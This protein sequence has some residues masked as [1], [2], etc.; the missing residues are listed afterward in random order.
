MSLLTDSLV[1]TSSRSLQVRR[2]PDLVVRRQNYLS[3]SYWVVKDPIGLKYFR[4]RDGEYAIL[5]MLDAECTLDEIKRRY[6]EQ[7]APQRI[8]IEELDR[9]I[10]QLHQHNLVVTSAPGQGEQLKQRRNKKSQQE[11]LSKFT[12]VLAIRFRG[13]DPDRLLTRI[14]PWVRWLFTGPAALAYCVLA[15]SALLLVLVQFEVF[16]GKL[17]GFQQFFAPTNWLLLAAVLGV[18]KVLH[19]FGHGLMCKHFK[20]ECHEMG[21]MLLVLTPCLYC[22]VSDSWLLPSK[23]QRAAIGAAGIFVELILASICTFVWWFTQPG[24]INSICLSVMFVSSVSTILFNG[25]PLLRYDGYYILSDLMEIPNLRQKSSAILTRQLGKWC[26]G[27][28]P[29]EDPFLPRTNLAMFAAYAM[30]SFVYRWIVVLGIMFFLYKIFEPYGLEIFGQIM[31]AVSL[32]GLVVQPL[33]KLFKYFRVPGRMEK[34]K[35]R[36]LLLSLGIG[37][38]LLAAILLIPIPHR[39]YCPVEVEPYGAAPVYIEVPGRLIEVLVEPGA[40]VTKGQLLARLEDLDL[41]LQVA[42]LAGRR[43]E[44]SAQLAALTRARF[45]DPLAD[46]E[47]AGVRETLEAV[48]EELQSKQRQQ[49]KLQLVAEKDG[50]VLPGLY[51]DPPPVEQG[52]LRPWSGALMDTRNEGAWCEKGILFCR[53]GDPR[54]LQALLVVDEE[55]IEFVAKQ[56]TLEILLDSSPGDPLMSQLEKV[57]RARMKTASSRLS[58]SAGGELVTESDERGRH[59]LAQTAYQAVAILPK[60]ASPV[61]LGVRGQAKIFVGSQSIG[62]RIWRYVMRTFAFHL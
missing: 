43:A 50:V 13:I 36:N 1:S 53:V 11:L 22:D 31:V 47:L 60:E 34:V 21:V 3:Q 41:D 18:T 29:P 20:G 35:P 48:T 45:D 39:V 55:E 44:L 33:W 8:T 40:K 14:Y 61:P 32:W 5:E 52:K 57:G 7:F 51:R 59:R 16:Q 23:W 15:V 42:E 4:F 10:A 49:Q 62:S 27:I 19:E 24:T 58:A 2:R 37:V 28:E 54:E 38:P 9:F 6:D 46:R 30:A 12:N 56:Q 26:L 25:N 17:P